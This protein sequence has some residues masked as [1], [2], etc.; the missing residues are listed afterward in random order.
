MIKMLYGEAR[1]SIKQL[2][3]QPFDH[4]MSISTQIRDL[5][6]LVAARVFVCM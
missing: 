3:H 6:C 5:S 2:R 4:T 1:I